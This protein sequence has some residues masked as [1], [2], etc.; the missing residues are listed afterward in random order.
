MREEGVVRCWSEPS[1]M[2]LPPHS[3]DPTTGPLL[4]RFDPLPPLPHE[5]TFDPEEDWEVGVDPRP[6]PPQLEVLLGA[7][8]G[9]APWPWCV[10]CITCFTSLS[11]AN[12]ARMVVLLSRQLL[13]LPWA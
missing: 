6:D 10:G 3:D 2:L 13:R 11:L 4:H 7:G 1:L 9:G 5:S 12:S 8:V